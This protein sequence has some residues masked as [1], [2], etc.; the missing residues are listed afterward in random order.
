MW[1]KKVRPRADKEDKEI[2]SSIESL[3][4]CDELKINV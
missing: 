4:L 3:K 2:P 1:K